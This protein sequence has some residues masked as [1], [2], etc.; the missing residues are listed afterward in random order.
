[1]KFKVSPT[2]ADVVTLD[3]YTWQSRQSGT[4]SVSC[5]SNVINGE[6]T[7]MEL[8]LNNGGVKLNMVKGAGPGQWTYTAR[9]RSRPTNVRCV[10][11]LRGQSALV[12]TTTSRRKRGELG[13]DMVSWAEW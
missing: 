11:N 4:I 2:L 9:G 5:H 1:V 13:R 12:T 10:S 3:T 7:K 8:H 6:N